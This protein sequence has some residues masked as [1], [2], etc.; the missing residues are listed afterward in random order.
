MA[1]RLADGRWRGRGVT[2]LPPVGSAPGCW[3]KGM[4]GMRAQGVFS[5]PLQMGFKESMFTC[6]N[7][8]GNIPCVLGNVF[9]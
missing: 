4:L 1:P 7:F 6:D 3:G 8:S 5:P 2:E 9:V